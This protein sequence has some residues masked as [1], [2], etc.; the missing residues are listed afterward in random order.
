MATW[1]ARG[2]PSGF[3][4]EVLEEAARR[5]GYRLDW[6]S[7]VIL[8]G[9]NRALRQHDV[10][11]VVGVE[12]PER[13]REF[14]VTEP[15]W[16]VGV[17]ALV[18][19]DSAIWD[20]SGLRGKRLAVTPGTAPLA[21]SRYAGTAIETPRG[22]FGGAE[23]VCLGQAD[24][25]LME[26]TFLRGTLLRLPPPC[27]DLT[28]RV[29]DSTADLH[30]VLVYREDTAGAARALKSALDDL[31]ADGTLAAIAA[32]HP[33]LSA[34]YAVQ[35]AEAMR[36]RFARRTWAIAMAAALLL[37]LLGGVF[38]LKLSHSRRRLREAYRR[39]QVDLDARVKAEA[40]LRDSEARFRALFDSAPQSVFAIGRDNTIVFANRR[41][42]D[43]F[44]LA[45]G[46]LIGKSLEVL[47]PERLH[48]AF[49]KDRLESVPEAFGLRAGGEEFPIEVVLGSVETSE[50]LTLAFVHD[51]SQRVALER[52]L[53]QS[54]KLEC[55]GHLAGGVAHDFNNLLTVIQGYANIALERPLSGEDLREP[56]REI[57]AAA[58]RAGALTRQLLMFSRRQVGAPRTISLNELLGN[59][60]KMLRRL[61]G[62]DIQLQ[63]V[64]DPRAA[65][66]RADPAHVEQVVLNLSINARDAM[67]GGG[68]LTI[69]T[70]AV[71]VDTAYTHSHAEVRPGAYVAL[72]VTDTG[73]G[74][75]PEV[76]A[77]I[78]E[79]FFTTKQP[80]KGTGL[81]L[82][83][84]Y[85]IVR[86]SGGTISVYSEPGRG[87][88]FK[89][90]L[91]A[92]EAELP[93]TPAGETPLTL[94][95]SETILLA[96]DEPGV[97]RFILDV[98][99]AQGYR[100][101]EAVDGASA[102]QIAASETG[103]IHLLLTDLVMPGMSGADLAESF[104]KLRPG[105]PVILMS[106][107]GDRALGSVQLESLIEKPF[108]PEALLRRV[109]E[110]LDKQ[111]AAGVPPPS[112]Q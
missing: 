111:S 1:P 60:E 67:P 59:L 23:A 87:S 92:A 36:L 107:Y 63:F 46:Q 76:Q 75:T 25:A 28:L 90:L 96:E 44:G 12:T 94:S 9:N 38:I 35:L 6:R 103:P 72:K 98:L 53:M 85:G 89:I 42:E 45:P 69:E 2:K 11:L 4:I 20:E 37:A 86:Q 99:E 47:L 3:M 108:A 105:A 31:T 102:S 50:G 110:A 88:T 74:M 22:P 95:G 40:A 27:R 66:V 8:E 93:E 33:P 78:F 62:E 30:F 81:G 34:P 65:A 57:L 26:E 48:A 68:K 10:D 80:G 70:A 15:W 19:A 84:V 24:A 49:R 71:R 79:P 73:F 112:P 61:I 77:Q 56:L 97:R 29:I 109:R 51:I 43:M 83:T 39:L 7:I 21:G 64:L 101:L 41:C 17:A 13:R 18:R 55:V 14:L 82:S 16:A 54:Q 58:D 52:Q 32:R 100:V 91:P 5:S 106:G 104:A